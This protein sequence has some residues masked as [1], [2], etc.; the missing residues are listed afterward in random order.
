MST[1]IEV[2][3]REILDSRGNPTVEADVVA[4][5]RRAA[6]ARRCRAAPPP[7]STRRSSCATATRSATAARACA[8]RCA[9]STRCI[10][11]AARGDGGGRPDRDRRRDDGRSTAR[12][13]RA[14]SAPTRSWR[15]SLAVARAA[16]EDVGLPLYRY[17]GGPMA[18]VLPVPMMNILN[19]GAHAS[20]QRGRPGVHDRAD[21]RRRLPRGAPHGRRGLPRA[22]EGAD[23]KKGSR[24]P[25]A[26]RAASR[27]CCRPTR[28]RSTR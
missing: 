13:T 11:P 18:R 23:G 16:A 2:H 28:R 7:A 17:L 3:A 8:R 20:Q 10:G 9:T 26:T 14:S 24:P 25:W 27:R 5:E 1:I 22:Q 19:G 21:R 4:V 6:A 15:V 12:R